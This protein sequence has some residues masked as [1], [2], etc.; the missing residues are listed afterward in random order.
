MQRRLLVVEPKRR[1]RIN[2]CLSPLDLV[3][4]NE[5]ADDCGDKRHSS[6]F[7]CGQITTCS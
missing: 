1:T 7:E 2:S 4:V 5:G 3:M 6:S